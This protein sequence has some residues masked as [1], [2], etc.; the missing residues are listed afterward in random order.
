MAPF[1]GRREGYFRSLGKVEKGVDGRQNGAP[2]Y[3]QVVKLSISKFVP[4]KSHFAKHIDRSA[5]LNNA[6]AAIS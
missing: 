3:P 1:G 6:R 2:A 5:Y 4:Q